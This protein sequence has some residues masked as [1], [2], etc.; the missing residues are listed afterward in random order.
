MIMFRPCVLVLLLC[1]V[2]IPKAHAQSLEAG[3]HFASSD[4]SEFEG[5]DRGVGGRLTWKATPRLGVDA[6]VT[7]YPGDYPG[8]LIAFSGSRV[9]GLFGVTYGPQVNRVRPFVKAG[10]GF[11]RSS[12]APEG[13]PCI[14]I[15]PPPLNCLMAAGHTMP[16]FEF[17]GGVQIDATDSAFLRVDAGAR[18]LRYPGP[19]FQNGLS[20]FRDD[21]FWGTALRFAIGAGLRLP[22]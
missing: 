18:M 6:D 20:A 9:E 19:A 12:E 16:A 4:W 7:W 5:V 15:F 17:G 11:L 10:A 2:A 22:Q 3:V 8:E 13:F 1:S 14:A 21:N